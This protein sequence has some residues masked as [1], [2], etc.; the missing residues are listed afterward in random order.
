MRLVRGVG[1]NDSQ[2]GTKGC[3]FYARWENMLDRVYSGRHKTYQGKEVCREWLTFSNFKSWME[4]QDWEGKEL[5][6]DLLGDGSLYSPD[7][8]LFVSK[9]VNQF[10]TKAG[11]IQGEYPTGVSYDKRLKKFSAKCGDL[12]NNRVHLGTFLTAV[13]AEIA[14]RN[15]KTKLAEELAGQQTNQRVANAILEKYKGY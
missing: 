12:N 5:D 13:D 14:Y 2:V 10:M 9:S 1:L 7:T 11:S 3:P 8:C 4:V 15:Y 6:K